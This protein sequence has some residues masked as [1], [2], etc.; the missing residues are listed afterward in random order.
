M[1]SE[2]LDRRVERVAQARLSEHQYVSALDVLMGLGW[3]TPQRVNE[4]RQGR[5]PYLERVVQTNLNKISR[6]M[7]A[8]RHWARA[9]GLKPSETAYLA[10]T[11]DRRPLQFSKS[12]K[13]S[14]ER[15]YRTHWLTG[16]SALA[17]CVA[18]SVLARARSSVPR[19]S[20]SRLRWG[21]PSPRSSAAPVP[22]P[23]LGERSTRS[24]RA[25]LLPWR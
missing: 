20:R 7:A 13:A 3:L 9:E 18:S 12:G 8:F 10:R 19:A 14:I 25:T 1:G 6:A 15:A 22:M 5:V 4:W 2:Q 17:E 11:R 16:P 21:T 23:V 24:A